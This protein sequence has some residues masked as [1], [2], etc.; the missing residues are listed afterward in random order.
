[1]AS[2]DAGILPEAHGQWY[3]D[4]QRYTDTMRNDFDLIHLI[5]KQA[6]LRPWELGEDT[7]SQVTTPTHFIWGEDD[8][9][10]GADVAEWIFG[11]MP[12][13]TVELR[14]RSG[15][16]PWLDAPQSVAT[17]TAE[18]LKAG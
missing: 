7:L 15:H 12:N 6:D 5:G 13:A 4:L 9:F 18:F 10:G 17:A 2:I 11:V 16:L 1:G 14:S 8:T 3:M